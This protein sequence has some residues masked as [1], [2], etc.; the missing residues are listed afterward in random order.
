MAQTQHNTTCMKDNRVS[1]AQYEARQRPAL[2]QHHPLDHNDQRTRHTSP[3]LAGILLAIVP[4]VF[5]SSIAWFAFGWLG[6]AIA[7]IV[8]LIVSVFTVGLLRST[9]EVETPHAAP[10]PAE[11]RQVA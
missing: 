5:W 4:A 2:I 3:G 7:A 10:S 1:I 9:S 11:L 6:A 8:V